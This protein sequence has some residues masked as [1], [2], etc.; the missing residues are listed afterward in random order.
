MYAEVAAASA[1]LAAKRAAAAEA[2]KAALVARADPA[3][4]AGYDPFV[5]SE[6][7][8][9]ASAAKIFAARRT[10]LVPIVDSW[11]RLFGPGEVVNVDARRVRLRNYETNGRA[12]GI[13]TGATYSYFPPTAEERV[14]KRQAHPSMQNQSFRG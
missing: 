14:T 6:G 8:P 12:G 11:D 1:A 5:I 9:P 3:A 2:R 13:I 4:R 10:G 7:A